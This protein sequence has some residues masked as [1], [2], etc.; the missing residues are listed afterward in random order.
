MGV[1]FFLLFNIGI[2]ASVSSV[3]RHA[4]SAKEHVAKKPKSNGWKVKT[5]AAAIL[6]VILLG[7]VPSIY[8][9]LYVLAFSPV[10]PGPYK[11]VAQLAGTA[12]MLGLIGM[13]LGMYVRQQ[14]EQQLSVVAM[15]FQTLAQKLV[16][17]LSVLVLLTGALGHAALSAWG[18]AVIVMLDSILLTFLVGILYGFVTES[19]INR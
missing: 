11:D 5:L 10:D 18:E 4:P 7:S 14:R 6:S 3:V 8:A 15:R 13:V 17:G 1:L 9:T 2:P 19:F 12:G 16:Y